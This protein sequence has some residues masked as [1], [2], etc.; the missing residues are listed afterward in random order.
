MK[1]FLQWS[2]VYLLGSLILNGVMILQDRTARRLFQTEFP[3]RATSN[4][5]NSDELQQWTSTVET[6]FHSGPWRLLTI[7]YMFYHYPGIALNA[8]RSG[9]SVSTATMF[10]ASLLVW[11][12]I[13]ALI[14]K[15][16]K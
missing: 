9:D 14:T 16:W 5:L 15:P 11:L 8:L 13:I 3:G 10:F 1:S 4:E 6:R 12:P 7:V 2:A